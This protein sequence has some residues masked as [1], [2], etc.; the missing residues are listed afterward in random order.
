MS[1]CLK[2]DLNEMPYCPPEYLIKAAERG[3]ESLNRYADADAL[4]RLVVLLAEYA[5]VRAE[6]I[7]VGPGSDL[8]LRETVL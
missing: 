7:I 2:L 6:Q 3:L 4:R 5:G 8:L 1:R